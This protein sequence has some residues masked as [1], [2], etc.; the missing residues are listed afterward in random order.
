MHLAQELVTDIQ[1]SGSSRSFA[2]ESLKNEELSG[3]P[4]KTDNNQLR[5]IIKADLLK[6]TQ[7][8]AQELN[9]N[10]SLVIWYFKQIGKKEKLNKWVPHELTC[11]LSLTLQT[12]WTRAHQALCLWDSPGKN[13]GVSCHALLQGIFL[14]QGLNLHL[15]HLLHLQAG[16]LPLAS[17]GKPSWADSKPKKVNLKCCLLLFYATMNHF[18]IRLWRVVKSGFYM[19]T[20]DDQLSG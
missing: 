11:V 9:V 5:A 2:K 14:T 6:T 4:S 1:C 12:P 19:T 16:S 8:V 7:E 15:L 20:R 13:T 18:S 10:H 3:W 17:C